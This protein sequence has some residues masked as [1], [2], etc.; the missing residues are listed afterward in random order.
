MWEFVLSET[1]T[2]MLIE[3]I[4]TNCTNIRCVISYHFLTV[5][6]VPETI[7]ETLTLA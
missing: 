1:D 7:L 4:M 3:I 5:L 6:F 2:V